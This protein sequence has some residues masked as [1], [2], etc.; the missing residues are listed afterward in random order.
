MVAI[1][2]TTAI[3]KNSKSDPN[4]YSGMTVTSSGMSGIRVM[5]FKISESILSADIANI[6]FLLDC[7]VVYAL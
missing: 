7:V 4:E 2:S 6:A 1:K 5:V 3:T